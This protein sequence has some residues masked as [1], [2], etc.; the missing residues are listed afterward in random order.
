MMQIQLIHH[1]DN[2]VVLLMTMLEIIYAFGI[3]FTSCELGQRIGFSYDE[4]REIVDQFDW[5]LFPVEIQRIWPMLL[6]F[7]HQS[8]QLKCF[9]SI[10]CNRD[11]FKSV[12]L[13]HILI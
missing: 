7:T 12:S 9:G 4:C 5:Y 11:T 8:F 6:N 3:L 13:K 2:L 1:S 10:E